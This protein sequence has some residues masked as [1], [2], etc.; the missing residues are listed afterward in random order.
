[1][2]LFYARVST[3]QQNEERQIKAATDLGIER[4]Y[5]Y[6]DKQSGKNADRKQ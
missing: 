5:I 4:E 6:I 3:E 2:K 1:M